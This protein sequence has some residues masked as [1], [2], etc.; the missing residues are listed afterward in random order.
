MNLSADK[1]KGTPLACLPYCLFQISPA[2]IKASFIILNLPPVNIWK[3][4]HALLMKSKTAK[5]RTP[6]NQPHFQQIIG[7]VD[8]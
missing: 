8:I 3:N 6:L 2:G 7:S 4:T 5:N 1:N